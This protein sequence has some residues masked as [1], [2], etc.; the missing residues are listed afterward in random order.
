MQA[1]E[2]GVL[3]VLLSEEGVSAGKAEIF[4]TEEDFRKALA[5]A[6]EA[7]SPEDVQEDEQAAAVVS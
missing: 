6:A 7:E 3:A 2:P 4:G 1:P 5:E